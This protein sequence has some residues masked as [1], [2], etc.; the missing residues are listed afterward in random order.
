MSKPTCVHCG[1]ILEPGEAYFFHEEYYCRDCLEELTVICD[2]CGSRIFVED[3]EGNGR[4][5]LCNRCF[6]NFYTTC[7]RCGRLIRNEDAYYPDDDDDIPY[8]HSCYEEHSLIHHYS[9]KPDPVFYGDGDRFFGVE[10]E[11]DCG[12]ESSSNAKKMLDIANESV[13]H[14]YCKHDGSLDEGFEI[15]THPMTL[16]YH[17]NSMPWQSVLR[18]LK[19]MGYRSHQTSTAGL[20]V[21]VNRDSLGCTYHEQEETIARIL[22][23]VEK[24]WEELV[25]FSRRTLAQLDRWAARYGF[26]DSPQDILKTAKGGYGRYTSVNLSNE[27]TVE[28]R[29]FR[30]TLKYDSILATLQLVDQLCRVAFL[31]SDE[32]IRHLSW[33]TF[34]AGCTQPELIQYL[35]ERRLYINEPVECEVDL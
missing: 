16:D 35:K 18:K 6:S 33:T 12:G 17:S 31:M 26:K 5:S 25:K 22:Y 2:H 7:D 9:F 32:E 30:G 19:E 11:V 24:F 8:C 20:H 34:V 1:R 4:I 27:E 23:L 10:L 28:F 3:D 14:I 29:I 13:W 15:V 21:H